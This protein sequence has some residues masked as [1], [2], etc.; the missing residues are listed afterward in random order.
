MTAAEENRAR[1][2]CRRGMLELDLVLNR[3]MDRHYAGLDAA[4]R[5]AFAELLEL[6]DHE[7]WEVIAGLAPAPRPELEGVAGMLARG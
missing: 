1:W 7:L 5:R 3:F 4:Q 6:Q 2:H